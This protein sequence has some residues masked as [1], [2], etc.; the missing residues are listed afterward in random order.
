MLQEQLHHVNLDPPEGETNTGWLTSEE[1]CLIL[2]V[3]SDLSFL[4]RLSRHLRPPLAPL[5]PLSLS[6]FLQRET[7]TQVR[8]TRLRRN[9]PPSPTVLEPEVVLLDAQ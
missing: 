6:S 1:D 2:A 9:S 4:P 5:Q 3:L 7:L 8:G